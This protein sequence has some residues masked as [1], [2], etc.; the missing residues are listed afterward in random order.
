MLLIV[1]SGQKIVNLH[2]VQFF[3]NQ[4]LEFHLQKD[5]SLKKLGKQGLKL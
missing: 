1:Q 5:Y 3:G 2:R 4:T